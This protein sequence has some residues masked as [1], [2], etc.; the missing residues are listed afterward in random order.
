MRVSARAAGG[1][2]A[3]AAAGLLSSA[4]AARPSALQRVTF[5]GDSAP[6][7]I[8]DHASAAAIAR[9]GVD[10]DFQLAPCRR[11]DGVSCPHG[12]KAPPTVVQLVQ[13][14]GP[15]LAPTVVVAVGYNDYEDQY[16]GEIA[17]VLRLLER[18]GAKHVLWLT[19]HAVRHPY[20]SMN[21]DILAAAATH[22][23]LTVVDWNGEAQGHADWFEDDGIHL[24]TGGA[25]AM[26][27]LIHDTLV[28][29]G[30][31]PAPAPGTTVATTAAAAAPPPL[32]LVTRSLPAAHRGRRYRVRLRAAAG[33]PPYSWSFPRRPPAGLHERPDGTIF[34]TPSGRPGTFRLVARLADAAGARRTA[35][36]RLRVLR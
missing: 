32:R 31:A 20:L 11:L 27:Q 22:P 1:L 2:A 35:T 36:L 23:E 30:V 26:A 7:G 16:A 29:L 25:L 12:G 9:G 28:R 34:G 14:L 19:L 18:A 8:L 6:T 13:Q 3:L 24:V 21:D 17:T 4:V 15:K 10:M 33:T 5:I